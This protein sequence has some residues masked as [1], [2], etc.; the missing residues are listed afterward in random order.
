MHSKQ[1]LIVFH[2]RL[3][4]LQGVRSKS[5]KDM[6]ASIFEAARV[7]KSSRNGRN[8]INDMGHNVV[9]N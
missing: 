7:S 4:M 9:S 8:T 1:Q 5:K 3:V 2:L 6:Q